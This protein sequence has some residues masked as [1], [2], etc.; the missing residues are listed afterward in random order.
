[1]EATTIIGGLLL[2]VIPSAVG[3]LL[4]RSINSVDA[5]IAVL[6]TKVDGLAK[7]DEEIAIKVADLAARV[8]NLERPRRRR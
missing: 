5:A 1:M 8:A 4:L 3:F 7:K 6:S 2:T